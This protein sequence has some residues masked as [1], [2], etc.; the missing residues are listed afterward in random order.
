MRIWNGCWRS[1]Q[2]RDV[3]HRSDIDLAAGQERDGAV[4]IDGEAA[5][6]AAE[7]HAGD[8]LIR[9]EALFEQGPRFFAASLFARELRFAVLVFHPLEV[10]LDGIA[11][12][13]LRLPARRGKFAQRDTAFRFQ[14]D[15]DQHAVVFDGQHAAFDDGSFESARGAEQ[16]IE[17]RGKALL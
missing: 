16:F 17:Q 3:A 7:N 6:D 10:D 2:R 9:L 4:E 15:I 1:Q 14:S 5:F 12:L 11:R 8:A 13:D